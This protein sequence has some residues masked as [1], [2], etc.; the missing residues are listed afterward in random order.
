MK[1]DL[2]D[3][4]LKR[5]DIDVDELDYELVSDPE[6]LDESTLGLHTSE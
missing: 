2:S 4:R 3:A 6:E 5:G 1:P